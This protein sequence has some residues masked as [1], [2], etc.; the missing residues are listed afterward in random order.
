VASNV[1]GPPHTQYLVG[2]RVLAMAPYVPT[3][4]EIRSCTAMVSYAGRLTIGIT[5]DAEALPDADCLVAAVARE[6]ASLAELPTGAPR[7]P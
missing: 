5:A 2:R 1:P 3:A 4:Q 7:K 6:L